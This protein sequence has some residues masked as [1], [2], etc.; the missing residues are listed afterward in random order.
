[1][2]KNA[3]YKHQL[4]LKGETTSALTDQYMTSKKRSKKDWNKFA[5]P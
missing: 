1:M 5:K 2:T 4:P 3:F